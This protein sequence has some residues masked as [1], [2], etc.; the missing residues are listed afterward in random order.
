MNF[1]KNISI[2]ITAGP[3]VEEID[4]VRFVS[5]KS[6]GKQGFEIGSELTRRG[7]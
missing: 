3:T 6:S 1:L 2:L 4:P 7:A 5:N